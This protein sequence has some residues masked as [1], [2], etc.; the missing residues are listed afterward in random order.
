MTP[1]PSEAATARA[2][3]LLNDRESIAIVARV[4]EAAIRVL[5]LEAKPAFVDSIAT[6]TISGTSMTGDKFD[7]DCDGV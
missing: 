6:I 1:D 3:L 7:F 2:Q 4:H 5:A